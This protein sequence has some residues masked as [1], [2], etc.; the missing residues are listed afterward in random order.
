MEVEANNPTQF[1]PIR[2]MLDPT[3]PDPTHVGRTLDGTAEANN[4]T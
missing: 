1:N 2:Q 3:Q 4:P